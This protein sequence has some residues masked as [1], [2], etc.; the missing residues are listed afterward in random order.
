MH[1]DAIDARPFP[2]GMLLAA[3]L[4]IL[5]SLTFATVARQTGYGATRLELG[6]IATSRDV[7]FR[8]DVPGHISAFDAQSGARIADIANSGNGFV[9]VVIKG[10]SRDR[11][12]A[13]LS[14]AEPFRI[15]TLADGRSMIEDRATGRIVM[16]GAFGADNLKAFSQLLTQ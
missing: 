7:I 12:V 16:L 1:E 13:G 10:F 6:P 2:R 4:L 3:G 14:L 11:T 5:T 9:G 15:S 8:D